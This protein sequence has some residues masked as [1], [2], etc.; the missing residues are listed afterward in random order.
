MVKIPIKP[1]VNA[2]KSATPIVKEYV[3]KNPGKTISIIGGAGKVGKD[4]LENKETRFEKKQNKGKVHYR[5]IQFVKYHNEI[6]PN[7]DSYS[8]IQLISFKHELETYIKQIKQEEEKQ[9]AINKPLH[10]KRMTSWYQIKVQIEDKIKTKNY[11]E[12]LKAYNTASYESNY[13]DAKVIDELRSI[14]NNEDV[15]KYVYLYTEMN[16]TDIERDFS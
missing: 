6:L 12:L 7:L 2:A 16:M 9:L 8:Y 13:F 10:T 15:Y 11:E 14:E 5:K 1:I 3:K 4:F